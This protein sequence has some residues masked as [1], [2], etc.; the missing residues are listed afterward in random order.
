MRLSD[1][2]YQ[3]I[4]FFCL[5]V[6][7]RI[8]EEIESQIIGYLPEELASRDAVALRIERRSEYP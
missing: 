6:P 2:L 4:F 1:P 8:I 5:P 7:F 3:L